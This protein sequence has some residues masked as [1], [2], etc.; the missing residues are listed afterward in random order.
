MA[1]ERCPFI[2]ARCRTF[3]ADLH[4]SNRECDWLVCQVCETVIHDGDHRMIATRERFLRELSKAQHP[5]TG[6]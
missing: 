4:C 1:E 5:S 6:V 2:C 3:T